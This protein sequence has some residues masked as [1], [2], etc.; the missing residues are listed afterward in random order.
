M[1]SNSASFLKTEPKRIVKDRL[2]KYGVMTGGVMVLC[3][4]LLIFFYL[5]YVVKPV[6]NSAH[7]EARNGIQNV[8]DSYAAIGIEEQTEIAFGLTQEGQVHYYDVKEGGKG[9]LIGTD[10]VEFNGEVAAFAKGAPHK[11]FYGYLSQEGELRVVKPSFRVSFPNDVRTLTPVLNFPYGEEAIDVT[12]GENLPIARFSFAGDEGVLGVVYQLENNRIMFTRLEGEEDM[13]T[14]ELVWTPYESELKFVTG[15]V[16]RLLVSPDVSR[17]L[18]VTE[19][20][21]FVINT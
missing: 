7:I 21:V 18:V 5:L 13:F 9:T 19:D 15:S 1:S 16:K 2:A 17:V 4:L 14:E 6:F 11:G 10:Q 12:D 20:K 3:A 8:T